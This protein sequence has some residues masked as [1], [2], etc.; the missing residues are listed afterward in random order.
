MYE[1][2]PLVTTV[3]ASNHRFILHILVALNPNYYD[4]TDFGNFRYYIN[5]P[6]IYFA[7]L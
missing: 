7:H 4:T 3:H 1:I 5:T 6:K 2:Y